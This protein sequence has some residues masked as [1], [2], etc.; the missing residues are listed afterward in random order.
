M[1]ANISDPFRGLTPLGGPRRPTAPTSPRPAPRPP[2]T[3]EPT[4]ETPLPR[5]PPL[6]PIP[7]SS[8]ARIAAMIVECGKRRRAEVADDL[9][10][11]P[12]AAAIIEAG[13]RRR[14]E[15]D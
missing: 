12:T 6:A 2:R 10:D 14:G 13:R 3:E 4:R 5:V 15:I 7:T 8:A 1:F 9:P 11:D